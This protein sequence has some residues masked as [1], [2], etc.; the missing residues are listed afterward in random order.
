M[1]SFRLT[2]TSVDGATVA[3]HLSETIEHGCGE[4]SHGLANQA[5]AEDRIVGMT[6]FHALENELSGWVMLFSIVLIVIGLL[7]LVGVV[8][9]CCIGRAGC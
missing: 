7:L 4:E 6:P 1:S 3:R 2:I 8:K 5:M 9:R